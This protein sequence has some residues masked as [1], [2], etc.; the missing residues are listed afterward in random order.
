L[1]TTGG[2]GDIS[3]YNPVDNVDKPVDNVI[4]TPCGK[5]YPQD[6][7]RLTPRPVDKA[8]DK[9]GLSTGLSTACG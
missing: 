8:V 3:V 9:S 7:H 1:S 2:S 6:I 4:P 5:G